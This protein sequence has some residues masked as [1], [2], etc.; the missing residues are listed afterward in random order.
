MAPTFYSL[1]FRFHF[2]ISLLPNVI[3]LE[4]ELKPTTR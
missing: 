1:V 3:V 4:A 2:I